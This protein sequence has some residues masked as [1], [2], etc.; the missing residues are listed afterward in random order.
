[1]LIQIDLAK[2]DEG[3]LIFGVVMGLSESPSDFLRSRGVTRW[4]HRWKVL[5]CLDLIRIPVLGYEGGGLGK[6]AGCVEPKSII[7]GFVMIRQIG[8]HCDAWVGMTSLL[9]LL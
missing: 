1:M 8:V 6:E 9:D 7:F 3:C 2:V 4:G 5:I